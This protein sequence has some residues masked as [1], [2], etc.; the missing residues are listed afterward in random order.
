M[1]SGKDRIQLV[2]VWPGTIRAAHWLIGLGTLVLMVT[3]WL[4]A[5]GQYVGAAARD[6]H[7]LAAWAFA[8]GLVLRVWLL[9]AGGGVAGWRDLIP[10]VM[11]RQNAW[12][13]LRF[14]LSFGRAE[15]PRWYAHN[16]LWG[17]IYLLVLALLCAQ[18]VT[19]FLLSYNVATGGFDTL[20]AHASMARF[21]VMFTLLHV[22]AVVLHDLRGRTAEI[23]GMIS[24][25]RIFEARQVNVENSPRVQAASRDPRRTTSREE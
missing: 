1:T 19:G 20:A 5:S 22:A 24:G 7:L 11:Q 23:S 25:Y 4:V 9:F 21:V 12:L 13:T 10:D 8:A 18:A 15:L 2:E 17:P 16:P 14:Y 3:G 6:F